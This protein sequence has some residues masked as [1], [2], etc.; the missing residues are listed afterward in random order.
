M[1]VS[2]GRTVKGVNRGPGTSW[3]VDEGSAAW[4]RMQDIKQAAKEAIERSQR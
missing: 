2:S 4:L 1:F 3:P